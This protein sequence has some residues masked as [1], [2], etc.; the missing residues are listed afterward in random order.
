MKNN[1]FKVKCECGIYVF[2]STSVKQAEAMLK[3]HKKSKKHKERIDAI[4]G[5]RK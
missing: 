1:K 4:K 5:A 2:G 3:E